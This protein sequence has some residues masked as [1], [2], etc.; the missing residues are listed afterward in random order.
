MPIGLD[1][2]LIVT[3]IRLRYKKFGD[4]IFI[5]HLD[6]LRLFERAL[7]R[8]QIPVSMTKGFNPRLKL[9]F[10]LALQ[11]GIE[12]VSEIL[13]IELNEWIKPAGFKERLDCQLPAGI[14]ISM[15]VTVPRNEKSKIDNVVYHI[16]LENMNLPETVEIDNLLSCETLNITRTKGMERKKIDIRPSILS[17][18]KNESGLNIQI[19]IMDRGTAKP[20]DILEALGI[21]TE[22]HPEFIRIT[23]TEV[24]LQ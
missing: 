2:T 22:E 10:P 17:I 6:L 23:R 16:I 14:E 18:N 7:R 5:S 12:G 4:K 24:N 9:S 1:L 13:E 11:L 20:K 21:K 19:K 8:G 3:R 15:P